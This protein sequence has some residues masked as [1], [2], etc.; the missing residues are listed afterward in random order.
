MHLRF[1]R[2]VKN[3]LQKNWLLLLIL[4]VG[5]LVR[6]WRFGSIPPGLNQDEASLAYDAWAL[7]HYGIDRH[8][9]RFPAVLIAWGGGNMG[10]LPAILSFPTLLL[11][12]PTSIG[13]RLSA[14]IVN[15]FALPI[16][17]K[18]CTNIADRRTALIGTFLF[19][20]NP[21][22]I[23]ASRWGIEYNFLPAWI[24]FAIYFLTC[25]REN[26]RLPYFIG[27]SFVALS[28]YIYGPAPIFAPL[29]LIFSSLALLNRRVINIYD[30]V[31]SGAICFLISLPF[32]L[33]IIFNL[34]KLNALDL[35]FLS[36]P[37]LTGTSPFEAV[38][39]F[40]DTG[41][42]NI[43][44]NF[45]ILF[46]LLMSQHDGLL[47]NT[48]PGYGIIYLWASGLAF[49]GFL[50]SFRKLKI[51]QKS[52]LMILWCAIAIVISVLSE[53]NSNRINILFI[54]IIFFLAVCI[55]DISQYIFPSRLIFTL[56]SV[57]FV[58]FCTT[59]FSSFKMD[60]SRQFNSGIGNAITEAAS[61]DGNIC[62]TS[63]INMPYIFALFFGQEDPNI[64][65]STVKYE[66]PGAEFQRVT[67]FGRYIFG[68]KK[69]A[70]EEISTYVV[71]SEEIDDLPKANYTQKKEGEFIV[72]IP[73]R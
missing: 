47:Y 69:C 36:I 54:P 9:Y 12:G 38:S 42:I 46:S 67:S 58:F 28:V 63:K 22:H 17:Y 65:N 48:L 39:I 64:F 50:W 13:I 62:I 68:L 43:W 70:Q 45:K 14:L 55:R 27:S 66:N 30:I 53:P 44:N 11:F 15:I 18:L 49:F 19:C 34:F 16:F 8:G 59:Y 29:F 26:R 10:I 41:H 52:V 57:S 31:I 23:M 33:F 72:A 71:Y 73:I 37:R 5:I 21:W 4:L 20:T 3:F 32:I 6:T 40:S 7:L 25:T 56:F 1:L 61:H 60:I 35:P 51:I 24:L 2:K